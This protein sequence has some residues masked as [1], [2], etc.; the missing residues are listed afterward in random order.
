M[1]D[2]IGRIFFNY[3]L[4]FWK[5]KF[6]EFVIYYFFKCYE[7]YKSLYYYIIFLKIKIKI[8]KV[9]V[10]LVFVVENSYNVVCL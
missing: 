8:D 4:Y 7:F 10:F 1:N 9:Y 6:N 5:N 3:C 2:I